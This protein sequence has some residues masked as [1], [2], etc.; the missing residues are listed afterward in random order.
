MPQILWRIII[1]CIVA[2]CLMLVL[3]LLLT[4]LGLS[5]TGPILQ[6]IRVCL[7]LIALWYV[8]WGPPVRPPSI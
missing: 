5:I 2:I 6:L 8:I 1:V 3:P 7:A 4:V